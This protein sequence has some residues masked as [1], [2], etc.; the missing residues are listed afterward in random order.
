MKR[1]DQLDLSAVLLGLFFLYYATTSFIEHR[2]PNLGTTQ[3]AVGLL[4]GFGCIGVFLIHSHRSSD[5]TYHV[6]MS[7]FALSSFATMLVC[8]LASY[9]QYL[10]VGATVGS[11]LGAISGVY[12]FTGFKANF[13]D[14]AKS[15]LAP[16]LI[17]VCLFFV[18]QDVLLDTVTMSSNSL[19]QKI[20]KGQKV[21][22]NKAAFGLRAPFLSRYLLTWGS[23]LQGE[24]I[25]FTEN[26]RTYAREVV[27][28]SDGNP[29]VKDIGTVEYNRLLGKVLS[30]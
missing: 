7:N 24:M 15:K 21:F 11:L 30:P 25:V 27:G 5:K 23:P 8:Y 17:G 26:H 18:F 9:F 13:P 14:T 6:R 10:K 12:L 28:F 20:V 4:F 29:V 2:N 22:V 1:L 3:F 16:A 19:V